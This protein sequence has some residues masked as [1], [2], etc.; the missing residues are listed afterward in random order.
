M[1]RRC[2][3]RSIHEPLFVV[4]G[5][6]LKPINAHGNYGCGLYKGLGIAFK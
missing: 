6:K 4:A 2:G 3:S 1:T 5:S